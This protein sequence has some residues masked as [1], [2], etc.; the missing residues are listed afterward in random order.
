M[1]EA[2]EQMRTAQ[3]LDPLSLIIGVEVGELLDAMGRRDE[4]T[5]HYRRML[6]RHPD[7]YALNFFAAAHSLV[8]HDFDRAATLLGQLAVSL[9]ADSATGSRLDARIRNPAT[10][11]ATLRALGTH[12]TSS[13]FAVVSVIPEINIAAYRAQ[14]D[15]DGAIDALERA[16]D[17][18]AYERI[19]VSHV[20]AVLGPELSARPRTQAALQRFLGRLRA[21]R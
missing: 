17:G 8:E 2:L 16:V 20:H 15:D 1:A 6:E 5:A 7:T 21:R 10:R 3:R 13:E 18:P 11:A 12:Q 4:A 9:G 14:G 19:Y